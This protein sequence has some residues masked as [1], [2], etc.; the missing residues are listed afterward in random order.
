MLALN[1][2]GLGHGSREKIARGKI[3]G[4]K[5]KKDQ[6]GRSNGKFARA[7]GCQAGGWAQSRICNVVFTE[8]THTD[9]ARCTS[10][11]A[12]TRRG[13]WKRG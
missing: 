2:L 7:W 3:N 13:D 4:T 9:G 6:P 1:D 10:V 11:I 12:I 8:T 5:A